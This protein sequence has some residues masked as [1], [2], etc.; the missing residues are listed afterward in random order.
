[1]KT[2]L[3]LAISLMTLTASDAPRSMTI[4]NPAGTRTVHS[5]DA[6]AEDSPQPSAVPGDVSFEIARHELDQEGM[7]SCAYA[8][9]L[10]SQLELVS[11][12]DLH[13]DFEQRLAAEKAEFERSQ[14]RTNHDGDSSSTRQ[15]RKLQRELIRDL[16]IVVGTRGERNAMNRTLDELCT[17]GRTGGGA[18]V[19]TTALGAHAITTVAFFPLR[20]VARFGLGVI[21]AK[22]AL[23]PSPPL[24]KSLIPNALLYQGLRLAVLGGAPELLPI[25]AIPMIDLWASRSC[26]RINSKNPRE[27]KF[28]ETM[29]SIS[30]FSNQGAENADHAGI[31]FR[32]WA[33]RNLSLRPHD[34]ASQRVC[35]MDVRKQMLIAQ[36]T[37]AAFHSDFQKR[38]PKVAFTV[39]PPKLDGCVGI[40][41]RSDESDALLSAS[42]E[43]GGWIQGITLAWGEPPATPAPAPSPTSPDVCR[44][45]QAAKTNPAL[46]TT[47][48]RIADVMGLSLDPARYGKAE[49]TEIEVP[50]ENRVRL[51][52][53]GRLALRNVIFLIRPTDEE[54]AE[55]D[56]LKPELKKLDREIRRE[57]KRYGSLFKADSYSECRLKQEEL[58]FDIA[59]LNSLSQ[60]KAAY[61][62]AKEV[63]E[64]KSLKQAIHRADRKYLVGGALHLKWEF[65]PSNHLQEVYDQLHAGDIGNAIIVTHGKISGKLV[66]SN[67]DEIPSSFFSWLSP[68]LMSLNFYSCY[69]QK[70]LD[71]YD[72]R[73]K[74]TAGPSAH[75]L[76]F[77]HHVGLTPLVRD[78]ELAPEIALSAFLT[79][80]DDTLSRALEGNL[81]LEML[82]GPKRPENRQGALCHL[83]LS[84]LSIT[85]GGFA[86]ILNQTFIG[87]LSAGASRS[88]A[89]SH[90]E[91]PCEWVQATGNTLVIQNQSL[92]VL[93]SADPTGFSVQL[94][95]PA[96]AVLS[97][98][99][100]SHFTRGDGS[101]RGSRVNF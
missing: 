33:R 76:R 42:R 68:S 87:Q 18:F 72:L 101:Y 9:T 1:M 75:A 3:I 52:Q 46:Q 27:V 53:G 86:L 100:V 35:G 91:F 25:F 93:S 89:G 23:Q 63:S 96:G 32:Q 62:V 85:R 51:K 37:L 38:F 88:G 22:P 16:E 4:R 50:F 20:I 70:I 5:L 61:T 81:R 60:T 78:E 98:S 10:R 79:R 31:E 77:T 17:A 28:C 59:R 48:E 12:E 21:T 34:Q 2:S 64:F 55:F 67:S 80:V 41:A 49:T 24:F 82:E 83:D 36:N 97:P 6:T 99:H 45:I 66:D 11:E 94:S 58:Q 29:R 26:D 84:G 7:L 57:F 13:T 54:Q 19:R 15:S 40:R 95:T 92:T 56:R 8:E 14:D 74:L 47:A 73:K 30:K 65:A 44:S 43:L 90:L 71:A 69:S 39:E